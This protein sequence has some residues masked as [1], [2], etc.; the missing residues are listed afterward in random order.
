[1]RSKIKR[2]KTHGFSVKDIA[3]LCKWSDVKKALV[4]H[5][6]KTTPETYARY[7]EIFEEIKEAWWVKELDRKE[8]VICWC[9]ADYLDQDLPQW[10]SIY[11]NQYSL[12][13]RPWAEVANIPIE[14]KTLDYLKREDLVAHFLYEITFY[15]YHESDGKKISGKLQ[16]ACDEIKAGTAKTIPHNEVVEKIEKQWAKKSKKKK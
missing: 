12:S 10:Y 2:H 6:K 16:K 14:N 5:Y 11:T 4:Y 13:F 8:R 3:R 1:M 9:P 15:G 7:E